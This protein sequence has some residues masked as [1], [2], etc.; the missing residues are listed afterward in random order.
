MKRHYSRYTPEMVS[1]VCGCSVADFQ[2][3]AELITSTY[4]PD[5]VGTIMYA[6]GWTH[7]SF[8]VQLIHATAM[9]Q[10]LLDYIVMTGG[11]LNSLRGH[12]NI[13]GATD[14]GMAYETRPGIIAIPQP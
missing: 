4:P 12:A 5:K 11:G 8:S 7:H 13:Q 9:L 1:R 14:T 3:A 2:K 10:L 6:L